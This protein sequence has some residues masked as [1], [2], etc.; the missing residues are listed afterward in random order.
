MKDKTVAILETRL[1]R[2]LAELIGKRGGRAMHAPALAEVPAL[3][4][5]V[6][7]KLVREL[8]SKPARLAIFQTGVGT[9]ALFG[10]TDSL[11][12]TGKLLALLEHMTVAVRGPK[13]TAALRARSVHIDL[14][15]K[16][17]YTTAEVLKTLHGTKL[18]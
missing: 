16:E 9:N 17:P 3:E 12:L 14:S 10:A 18:D 1:G 4:P 8:E 7:G 15:A 11:E 6:I 2:Q 13:P 5:A